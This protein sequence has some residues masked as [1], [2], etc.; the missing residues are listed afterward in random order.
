VTNSK[1]TFHSRDVKGV[2]KLGVASIGILEGGEGERE[3]KTGRM[4][5]SELGN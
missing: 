3:G 1:Q 4:K 5:L 2:T